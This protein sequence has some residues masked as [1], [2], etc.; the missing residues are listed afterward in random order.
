VFVSL[1][2]SHPLCGIFGF[3]LESLDLVRSSRAARSPGVFLLEVLSG[4]FV[5]LSFSHPQKWDLQLLS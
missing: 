5:S 4:V 1:Y 3:C 2:F